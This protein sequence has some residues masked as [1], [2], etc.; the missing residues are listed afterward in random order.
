MGAALPVLLLGTACT[1]TVAGTPSYGQGKCEGD[2]VQPSGSPYCYVVPDGFQ[3]VSQA[4]LG[5]DKWPSGVAIDQSNLI[6]S[7]I[8]PN[9]KNVQTMS[10]QELLG[11]TDSYVHALKGLDLKQGNGVLSRIPAGRAI[12][13]TG[14]ADS[15]SKTIKLHIYFVYTGYSVLQLNCQSTDKTDEVERGCQSILPT[16]HLRSIDPPQ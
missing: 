2:T 10:D 7:G 4:Y 15:G 14:S 6:I 16:I 3:K 5:N 1:A 12:E 8:L 13:Y 9:P 11:A